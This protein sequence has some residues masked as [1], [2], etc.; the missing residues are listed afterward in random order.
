MI[1][2]KNIIT[3]IINITSQFNQEPTLD[4]QSQKKGAAGDTVAISEIVK[5]LNQGKME[6]LNNFL[7]DIN[8]IV[9]SNCYFMNIQI[10]HSVLT[11]PHSV[12]TI[13]TMSI[14]HTLV[15]K[16][17]LKKYEIL[18]AYR[19]LMKQQQTLNFYAIR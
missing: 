1:I 9:I 8:C 17:R 10:P 19:L 11:I 14:Q 16:K 18:V 6:S 15:L 2:S 13:S 5:E 7:H 12:L 4:C 3:T